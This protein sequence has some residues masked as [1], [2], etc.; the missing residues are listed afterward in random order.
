M[1]IQQLIR[2]VFPDQCTNCREAV[3][4]SKSLCGS[5]WSD[6]SIVSGTVCDD[7]GAPLD[8]PT[9]GFTPRCDACMET[10]RPWNAGRTAFLYQG[11]GRSLVLKFKHADRPD[12]APAFARLMSVPARD[13]VSPD[14]TIT[15]VPAHWRR[16]LLRRYD[17]AELLALALA[18]K[19]G[20][21]AQTGI[22]KRRRQTIPQEKMSV[23][24]RLENQDRSFTV[25]TGKRDKVAGRALLL[26][27]DVMTTG[28]T[29]AA[30]T[31]ELLQAGAKSVNVLT[32]ARV[33]KG[34]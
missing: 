31:E 15:N 5:C 2:T 13:L 33:A 9:A 22:L 24:E 26:V 20:L 6:L 29:M 30:A 23:Q 4:T 25:P 3:E 7:C 19:I 1:G 12:L 18:R 21:P 16:R 17:Q 27:D 11:L 28:A 8:G 10:P 34:G 14:V 32:L